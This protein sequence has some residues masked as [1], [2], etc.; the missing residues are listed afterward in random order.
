MLYDKGLG[1]LDWQD[2]CNISFAFCVEIVY[3]AKQFFQWH[4][5]SSVEVSAEFVSALGYLFINKYLIYEI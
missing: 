4:V 1:L 3:M 2:I 5:F